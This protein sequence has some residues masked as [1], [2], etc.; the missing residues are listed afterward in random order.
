MSLPP[1]PPP[2]TS[3][4]DRVGQQAVCYRHSNRPAGRRCTRCGKWACTEC[5][6]QAAVGSHCLDCAKAARPDMKTRARYWN[7]RQPALVTMLL[8]TANVAVFVWLVIQDPASI[9]SRQITIGHLKLGLSADIIE[10]GVRARDPDGGIYLAEPGGWYRLVSSGFLHFGILHLLLNM[11]L[12]FL[13]GNMLEPAIGRVRFALVYFAALLAG[14][15]G[16]LLL[17]P[18]GLHGGASGAVFGLMGALFVGY[19]QRGVNPLTTGIGVTLVLNLLITFAIPG[20]SIGGHLGVLAGGVL[21]ALIVLAPRHRGY[22]RWSTFALP[23]VV[24]ALS[25]ALSVVGVNV[26]T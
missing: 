10:N 14:S 1:P 2:S 5:L 23:V 20:I 15:A 4:T 9:T 17:Q 7:A 24:I 6:V 25:V 11:Y 18:H 3:Q 22:P 26:A 12:L 21:C 8:I 16:A 19:R 13:L